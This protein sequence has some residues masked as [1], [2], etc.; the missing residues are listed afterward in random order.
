MDPSVTPVLVVGSLLAAGVVLA[1]LNRSRKT[2]TEEPT[3]EP[4]VPTAILTV[5]SAGKVVWRSQIVSYS[6][7]DGRVYAYLLDTAEPV[8]VGGDYVIEP[9]DLP[10]VNPVLSKYRV[11][12]FSGGEP[13]KTWEASERHTGD[14]RMYVYLP[15]DSRPIVL[16]GAYV[17]EPIR[18][19]VAVGNPNSQGE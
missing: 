17:I 9:L 16:G 7:G 10:A 13:V 2:P 11:T 14:H 5:Y 12:L 15:G 8:V 3:P 1:L 4:V 19:P 6:T 18:R